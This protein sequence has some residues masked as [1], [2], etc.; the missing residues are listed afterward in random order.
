M[1]D[2]VSISSFDNPAANID[3]GGT[4][5]DILTSLSIFDL[6]FFIIGLVFMGSLISAAIG[7]INSS[8]SPEGL[9]KVN[10]R[11]VNSLLGLAIVF[12]SYIIVRIV[13]ATIGLQNFLPF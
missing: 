1:E 7:Y 3:T 13:A 11:L 6:A 4:I 2:G 12:A 8:G 9:N 5:T 10:S